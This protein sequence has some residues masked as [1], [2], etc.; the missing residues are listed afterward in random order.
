MLSKNSDNNNYEL[1][2]SEASLPEKNII[3]IPNSASTLLG[4]YC[5]V[6]NPTQSLCRV[7]LVT[8]EKSFMVRGLSVQSLCVGTESS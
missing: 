5:K 7:N 2:N 8:G 1:R 4:S 3:K 6:H